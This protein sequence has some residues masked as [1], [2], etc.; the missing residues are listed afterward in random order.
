MKK[1]GVGIIGASPLNPSWAVAAHVP[2]A[3]QLEEFELR[4]VST[5]RRES[6]E[7]A[8]KAFG[9]PSF[10]DAEQLIAY[11]GVDLV[12]VSVRVPDHFVLTSAAIAAGKMVFTEWPL[13][14]N[15]EEAMELAARAKV[16]GVRT[17]VGL[18][19]RFSPAVQHA[20]D[21]VAQGY[22]GDVLS[23]SLV[24]SGISW[25][26][27]TSRGAAYLYDVKNGAT[28]LSVAMMH[29][30]DAVNYV[31]GDFASVASVSAIRRS[32]A[33]IIE[34][35]STIPVTSPDQVAVSGTLESGAVVSALYRSGV[36]RGTNLRWEINGTEGD[37]VL[38]SNVGNLQVADIALAGARGE[39]PAVSP[40]AL[41]ESLARS[42]GGLSGA[43]GASTLREYAA[44][45]R[46][47]R[48]GTHVAPDFE[49][50][51]HRHRLLAAIE[52][53]ARS[54]V[55]QKV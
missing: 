25:G 8:R 45:A 47:L 21:L 23:T 5:S 7:A 6:A 12:V 3:Q 28:T 49:Y 44:F 55:T 35:R 17:V 10:D 54:G 37:L 30:L 40:I 46:D 14:R 18:Q 48:D 43:I 34:D 32:T 52:T 38:T 29:A 20:R 27:E 1:I 39:E 16:A 50:A 15:L 13:G 41:P 24:G 53:A 36:S 42:P 11:P 26:A 2:A 51:L 19:A 4:A 9:V 33:R 22:V 31:L